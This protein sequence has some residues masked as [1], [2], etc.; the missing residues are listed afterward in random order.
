VEGSELTNDKS[1]FRMNK[2][3]FLKFNDKFRDAMYKFGCTNLVI[4]I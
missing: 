1:K 4:Y 3:R 2:K